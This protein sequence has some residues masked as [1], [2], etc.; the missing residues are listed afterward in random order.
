M[1]AGSI[2]G[3]GPLAVLDQIGL[4]VGRGETI[5]VLGPNGAGKSTLMKALSGLIRPVQGTMRLAAS[6]LSGSGT[7]CRARRLGPCSRGRQVFPP[8]DR[9]RE[10]SPW[11]DPPRRFRACGNRDDAGSISAIAPAPAQRGGSAV[12]RRTTDAC[13]RR[14]LLAR[15]DILLLTNRRWV[16][17]PRFALEL[18]AQL[19]RLRDEGKTLLIVDQMADHVLAIADRRLCAR[20]RRVVA[21]GGTANLRGAVLDDAYLGTLPAAVN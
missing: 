6:S 2:A 12:R 11:R 8:I 10:P 7:P 20:R 18:F 14:G 19:R 16:W 4:L 5:A 21:Q 9:C 15:P 1:C 17:R 3:Y 13:A